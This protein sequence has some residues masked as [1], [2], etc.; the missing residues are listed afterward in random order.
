MKRAFLTV[1]AML[2]SASLSHADLSYFRFDDP[3]GDHTGNTDVVRMDFTFDQATGDYTILLTADAANPF[4]GDFRIN[5]NL[6]NPDTGTRAQDP[7]SFWDNV[8]DYYSVSPVP[9]FTLTGTNTHLL[10]WDR[11]DRVATSSIPFGNPDGIGGFGSGT[12]DLPIVNWAG[13]DIAYGDFA[14]IDVSPSVVPV[15]VAV[16]LGAIGLSFAGWR[17]KRGTT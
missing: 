8:N 2:S 7:S 1:V 17:L 6:F 12:L 5:I 10:S 4:R 9:T 15:P 14:V 16:L 13:D 3:V 11:G